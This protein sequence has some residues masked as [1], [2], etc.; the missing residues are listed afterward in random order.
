MF[1][2]ASHSSLKTETA[3]DLALVFLCMSHDMCLCCNC[4]VANNCGHLCSTTQPQPH[5]D[6][7]QNVPQ[8]AFSDF[9]FPYVL[10]AHEPECIVA[11][12]S[13]LPLHARARANRRPTTMRIL[14]LFQTL[15]LPSALFS[16]PQQRPML[17]GFCACAGCGNCLH[18]AGKKCYV[19]SVPPP[20]RLACLSAAQQCGRQEQAITHCHTSSCLQNLEKT[21]LADVAPEPIELLDKTRYDHSS[22]V[23]STRRGKHREGLG[24]PGTG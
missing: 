9:Y 2:T 5:H 11:Q 17:F 8:R 15:A 3:H 12:S 18:I 16:C 22:K 6:R 4:R 13:I 14:R 1:S 23:G 20:C 19:L 10:V 24:R 7:L 21:P